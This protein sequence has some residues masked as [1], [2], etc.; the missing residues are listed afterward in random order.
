[1]ATTADYLNK[2]VAQKNAL[3]DNLVTKGITATQDETLET[4][5][6]KVLDISGGGGGEGIYPIGT[7]SR[8]TGDVV[9]PEGIESLYQYT[10]YKNANITSVKLPDTLIKLPSYAFSECTALTNLNIPD[11]ISEIPDNC[12]NACGSLEVVTLPKSLTRIGNSAFY[13]CS[14]LS[15]IIIPDDIGSLKA[16]PY[17][18]YGTLLGNDAITSLATKINS[19]DSWVFANSK[20]LT[21]V[22]TCIT[23]DHYFSDCTNLKKAT[24]LFPLSSGGMG[25]YTFSGCSKLETVMLPEGLTKIGS[26]AFDNCTNLSIIDIPN[27]VTTIDYCAFNKCSSLCNLN[28]PDDVLFSLSNNVFESSGITNDGFNN[29]VSHTSSIGSSVFKSCL[30]LTDVSVNKTSDGMFRDCTNLVSA[31]LNDITTISRYMFQG[32]TAL[33]TVSLPS[34]ITSD[35]NNCLTST[36]SSYYIFYGCTALEDVQLGQDWNMS[37]RLNVSNNITVESMV[38]MFNSLKDLTGETS[39]T[40]TLGSTNLDKLTDEQKTIATNKNWT[41]A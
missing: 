35:P 26:Y 27:S 19:T 25:G 32:C 38:T 12:C 41:L 17:A 36:S 1:M 29:I 3:A 2:L 14:K 6:P 22:T 21:E 30:S 9:V 8:P 33:K 28:L 20:N 5:V 10:F 37:L 39:K 31:V 16:E 40:L 4:L 24:I 18:F 13:K 7:D 34:T 15:N 23:Y 11:G